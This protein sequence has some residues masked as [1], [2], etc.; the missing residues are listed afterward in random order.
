MVKGFVALAEGLD[1]FRLRLIS[2]GGSKI[3]DRIASVEGLCNLE[4]DHF[5]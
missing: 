5:G 2:T 3:P 1:V 4:G